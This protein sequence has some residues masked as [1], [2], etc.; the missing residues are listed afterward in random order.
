MFHTVSVEVF[1]SSLAEWFEFRSVVSLPLTAGAAATR[2][3]DWAGGPTPKG[4]AHKAGREYWLWPGG[5][6]SSA[7]VC[8]HSRSSV[9]T[10]W[11]LAFPTARGPIAKWKPHVLRPSLKS[12]TSSLPPHLKKSPQI[13]PALKVVP[14]GEGR[15]VKKFV[16]IFLNHRAIRW[17]FTE[18]LLCAW[19]VE[20]LIIQS[21][22][23]HVIWIGGDNSKAHR[24]QEVA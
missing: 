9:L 19:P 7:H 4:L 2:R 10:T 3:L 20:Q 16:D 15:H 6:R 18:H 24:V 11:R 21:L 12:H 17:A 1:G 5:L 22:E 8:F 23:E 14:L 13:Q